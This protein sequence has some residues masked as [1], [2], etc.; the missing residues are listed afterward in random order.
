MSP[1]WKARLYLFGAVVSFSAAITFF[2]LY[3]VQRLGT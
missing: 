2:Y 1:L 3:L